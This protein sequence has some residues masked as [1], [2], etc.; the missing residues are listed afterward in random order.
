MPHV[1]M[2][3]GGA[4]RCSQQNSERTRLEWKGCV[5]Y[6]NGILSRAQCAQIGTGVPENSVEPTTPRGLTAAHGVEIPLTLADKKCQTRNKRLQSSPY[7]K[8]DEGF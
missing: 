4:V 6:E 5:V 8:R 7:N 2:P 1:I 3:W